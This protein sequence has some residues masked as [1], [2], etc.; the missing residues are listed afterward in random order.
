MFEALVDMSVRSVRQGG[1]GGR[2]TGGVKALARSVIVSVLV[3][4]GIQ[5]AL[6]FAH[7]TLTT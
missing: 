4:D 2:A 1:R 3:A 6:A 7:Q 5:S